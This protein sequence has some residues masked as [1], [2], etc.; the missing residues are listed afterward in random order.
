MLKT[1]YKD[2]KDS[3]NLQAELAWHLWSQVPGRNI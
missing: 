3:E 2:R 1:E